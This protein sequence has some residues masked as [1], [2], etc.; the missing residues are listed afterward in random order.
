[1]TEDDEGEDRYL[2]FMA[3]AAEAKLNIPSPLEDEVRSLCEDHGLPDGT[4]DAICALIRKGFQDKAVDDAV[5]AAEQRSE[6][7]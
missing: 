7:R 6:R 1:M 3:D 2:K 4:V 5:Y